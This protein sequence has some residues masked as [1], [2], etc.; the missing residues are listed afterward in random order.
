MSRPE[1]GDQPRGCGEQPPGSTYPRN[2]QGPTPQVRGAELGAANGVAQLG[3]QPTPRVRGAG[4]TGSLQR[5]LAGTNP[6]G[7]G[8][9]GS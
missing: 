5:L 6:A 8:N 4:R 7:A 2:L 1:D 3:D 9:R